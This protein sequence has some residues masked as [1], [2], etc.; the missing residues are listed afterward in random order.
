MISLQEE[1]QTA[2]ILTL[3][4]IVAMGYFEVTAI[5]RTMLGKPHLI[6][7]LMDYFP[8]LAIFEVI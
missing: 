6:N 8:D 1:R 5:T 2:K 3:V 7:F 4:I